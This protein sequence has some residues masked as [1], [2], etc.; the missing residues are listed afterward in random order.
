MYKFL[1]IGIIFF[2]SCAN[3]EKPQNVFFTQDELFNR[4]GVEIL[5][6]IN[7]MV[8]ADQ[9][10]R[11]YELYGTIDSIKIDS[12]QKLS[13]ETALPFGF[14]LQNDESSDFLSKNE[15]D[16]IWKVIDFL[17]SKHTKRMVEIIATYGYPNPARLKDSTSICN[18]SI[19]LCHLDSNYNDTLLKL[20]GTELA[21][22][23]IDTNQYERTKWDINGREG[24]PNLKGVTIIKVDPKTGKSDTIQN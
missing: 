8:K 9:D 3:T 4:D 14:E 23:R 22:G 1:F 24:I 10:I 19:L 17:Q 11:N 12:L 7:N 20:M 6:E 18:A 2:S 5:K 15:K 13:T 16:S 21:K